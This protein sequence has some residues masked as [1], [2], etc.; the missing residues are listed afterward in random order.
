MN[1]LTNDQIALII[2]IRE[3]FPTRSQRAVAAAIVAERDNDEPVWF[4]EGITKSRTITFSRLLDIQSV[5]F[6][7]LYGRIRRIDNPERFVNG[8]YLATPVAA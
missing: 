2:D 7:T 1:R 4:H 3:L 8:G 6:A 5:P